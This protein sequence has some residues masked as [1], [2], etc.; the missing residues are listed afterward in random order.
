MKRKE[1]HEYAQRIVV[2]LYEIGFFGSVQ[3]SISTNSFYINITQVPY[4]I[5]LSDHGN[6]YEKYNFLPRQKIIRSV[7]NGSY[8]YSMSYEGIDAFL[9]DFK[10][11]N[12]VVDEHI[13]EV[14]KMQQN[15]LNAYR[16]YVLCHIPTN[17]YYYENC[18]GYGKGMK[19][20]L[21]IH[22]KNYDEK[23]CNFL[24]FN[25]RFNISGAALFRGSSA[26]S[27][28]ESI[29]KGYDDV[30]NYKLVGATVIN[31]VIKTI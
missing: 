8:F 22:H 24:A 16:Q 31:G 21:H 12:N 4:K 17:T 25:F 20:M 18:N 30:S 9:S 14:K 23:L 5:R 15:V 13:T 10:Q 27:E 7:K 28:M 19:N 1:I 6:N 2:D 3:E 26:K 11:H 29:V